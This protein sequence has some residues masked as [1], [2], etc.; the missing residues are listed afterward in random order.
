MENESLSS[1]TPLERPKNHILAPIEQR[2]WQRTPRWT[3]GICP[4]MFGGYQ[5]GELP[6]ILAK[7][8]FGQP[9]EREAQ[10]REPV[11]ASTLRPDCLPSQSIPLGMSLEWGL[12]CLLMYER[13]AIYKLLGGSDVVYH[14]SV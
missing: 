5:P 10:R 11:R 2:S 12:V 13:V 14:T 6:T 7:T 4:L 1:D 9:A 8:A 3:L